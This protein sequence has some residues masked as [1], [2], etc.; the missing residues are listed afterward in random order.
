[1]APS[2]QQ[3]AADPSGPPVLLSLLL[4]AMEP[5]FLQATGGAR[6][7]PPVRRFG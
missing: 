2:A 5:V 6:S 1:L 7:A 4:S 3:L